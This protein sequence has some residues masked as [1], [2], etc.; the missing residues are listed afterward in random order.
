[1]QIDLAPDEEIRLTRLA[2]LSEGRAAKGGRLVVTSER[3]I[4]QPSLRSRIF[5]VA[6][7]SIP[8][9]AIASV[10]VEPQRSGLFTGG[11][12]HRV[13]IRLNDGTQYHFAVN[14]PRAFSDALNAELH[15]QTHS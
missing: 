4:F 1:M 7:F 9:P 14:R 11:F 2:A 10:E 6:A 5:G 15:P 8:R 3:V 13:V 12:R